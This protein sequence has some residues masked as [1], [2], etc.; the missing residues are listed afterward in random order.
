MGLLTHR[1]RVQPYLKFPTLSKTAKLFS[2]VVVPS[3]VLSWEWRWA[4]GKKKDPAVTPREL[5][6]PCSNVYFLYISGPL[7]LADT[8]PFWLWSSRLPQR[9]EEV[10]LRDLPP[11]DHIRQ[12][13][14][15]LLCAGHMLGTAREPA[16]WVLPAWSSS[17]G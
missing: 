14:P 6:P 11:Q 17:F 10:G 9:E 7:P 13:F 3:Y 4:R 5:A 12:W 1:P 15:M 16:S 2:R 8:F